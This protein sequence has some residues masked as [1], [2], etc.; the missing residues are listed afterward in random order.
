[1]VINITG[2]QVHLNGVKSNLSTFQ[3][4]IDA[5]TQDWKKRDYIAAHPSILIKTRDKEFLKSLNA[6][7]LK[8]NFSKANGYIKL[9]PPPFPQSVAPSASPEAHFKKMKNLNGLFFY[10]GTPVS[11]ET[12][13]HLARANKNLNVKTPYPYSNPPETHLSKSPIYEIPQQTNRNK[14]GDTLVITLVDTGQK[15][16]AVRNNATQGTIIDQPAEDP[17]VDRTA[18]DTYNRLAKKYTAN[19]NGE[20]KREEIKTMSAIYKLMNI[21]QKEKATPYPTIPPPPPLQKESKGKKVG[22]VNTSA[23]TQSKT[24]YANNWKTFN[25]SSRL[26]AFNNKHLKVSDGRSQKDVFFGTKKVNNFFSKAP[27]IVL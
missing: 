23:K 5:Y 15:A 27:K 24:L 9:A 2:N 21:E 11:Y 16:L 12:A 19:P 22:D 1:M 13:I 10:E 4:D 3:K 14:K 18:L 8:T 25:S 26:Q 17:G 20:I 7:F 6:E